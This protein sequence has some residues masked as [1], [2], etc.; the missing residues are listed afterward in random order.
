M[1]NENKQ[2]LVLEITYLGEGNNNKKFNC[3]YIAEDDVDTLAYFEN[4]RK[5]S[6]DTNTAPF[7]VDLRDNGDIEDTLGISNEV[8]TRITGQEVQE[9]VF[10][11][12][13]DRDFWHYIEKL[14]HSKW[15]LESE[16][17]ELKQTR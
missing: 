3:F 1:S 12:K 11:E 14:A 13:A 9:P 15:S 8:F 16:M 6:M 4:L 7:F 17:K 5:I 2:T 10:Y